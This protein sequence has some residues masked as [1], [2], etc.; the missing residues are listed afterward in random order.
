MGKNW[1]CF[2]KTCTF[3]KKSLRMLK[4]G[5]EKNL[6]PVDGELSKV[7]VD[8]RFDPERSIVRSLQVTESTD[9][10]QNFT[11]IPTNKL[12]LMKRLQNVSQG[13]YDLIAFESVA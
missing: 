1:D 13:P 7:S 3:S 5:V 12:C 10:F 8:M 2:D 9:E 4:M 6:A 11:E